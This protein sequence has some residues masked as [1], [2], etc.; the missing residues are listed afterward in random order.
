MPTGIHTNVSNSTTR[1]SPEQ[2]GGFCGH[3]FESPALDAN[4][5]VLKR[6]VMGMLESKRY[7]T[8]RN[9]NKNVCKYSHASIPVSLATIFDIKGVLPIISFTVQ[10][11]IQYQCSQFTSAYDTPSL[12]RYN[13]SGNLK[14]SCN[15]WSNTNHN[16]IS[17]FIN[18]KT[19]SEKQIYDFL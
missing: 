7:S 6:K 5:E 15:K 13:R 16:K 17:A 18:P 12:S 4:G 9:L 3:D 10:S 8:S 2:W 1:G 19:K 14:Y 11:D